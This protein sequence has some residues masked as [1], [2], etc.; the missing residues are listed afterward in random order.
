V[1]RLCVVV[2]LATVGA[3]GRL[4]FGAQA[5]DATNA[6][7][8]ASSI[9]VVQASAVGN[10]AGVST[11]SVELATPPLPGDLIVLSAWTFA[12]A[13]SPAPDGF[14]DG[15]GN[16]YQ[17]AITVKSGACEAKDGVLAMYYAIVTGNAESA[18]QVSYTPDG[19]GSQEIDMIAV[20]YAGLGS[21]T[22]DRTASLVTPPGTSPQM[23]ASGTTPALSVEREVVVGA[24]FSCSGAPDTVSWVDDAGFTTRGETMNTL[25]GGPG[26]VG[27]KIVDQGGS[28]SD[29]WTVTY[30]ADNEVELGAIATFF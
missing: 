20:E 3:C 28:Y 23:F 11:E 4:D 7:G 2:A 6:D 10:A 22:L 5:V 1:S 29:A 21:A 12:A 15:E 9:R 14:T 17:H 27:D 19:D 18:V 25:S 30:Q 16:V 13:S 8:A 26:I 24:A